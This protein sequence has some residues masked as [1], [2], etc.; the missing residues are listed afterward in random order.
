M[1]CVLSDPW[2]GFVDSINALRG[3]LG[4]IC[5]KGVQKDGVRCV[6]DDLLS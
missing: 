2:V 4:A 5:V 6:K 1:V 3:D